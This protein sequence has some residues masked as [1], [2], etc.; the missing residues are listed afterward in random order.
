MKKIDTHCHIHFEEYKKELQKRGW[1][2]EGLGP[3]IPE[4]AS[5]G[6]EK[7]ADHII[8]IMDHLDIERQV[9]SC[10]FYYT[11]QG[12]DKFHLYWV[13]A[14]NDFVAEF[15]SKYP[16]RFSGFFNLPLN[17]INHTIDEIHRASKAQGMVGI[18]L[19]TH[20]GEQM[21]DS[22]ELIPFYEEVNKLGLTLF[23]HPVLPYAIEQTPGYKEFDRLYRFIGFLFETTIAVTRMVLK[24][25]FEKF[26]KMNVIASHYGGMI[27]FV[28]PSIDILWDKMST[29]RK[30]TPSKSPSEY[31]KN[32]YVDTARPLK[33][34]TLQCTID[35]VG[36]D[37][38]LF[39]SDIPNWMER[40]SNSPKR[41]VS[42]IEGMGLSAQTEE[43]IFYGNAKRILKL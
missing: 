40:T 34:T 17:N 15:C 27:P 42:A 19:C 2:R 39:G 9:L 3:P 41:I 18:F 36:E 43:K 33:K 38:I 1:I 26:E 37:H 31:F 13:Q 16:D 6:I 22:P 25:I 14:I 11:T 7:Y 10:P 23:I 29:I 35:L 5:L 28:I 8:T 21:L 32:I 30:G 4:A 20:N 24:G 12:D